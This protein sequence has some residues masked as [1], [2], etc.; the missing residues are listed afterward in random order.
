MFR[1]KLRNCIHCRVIAACDKLQGI[2][3]IGANNRGFK[4]SIDCAFDLDLA[5]TACVSL[6]VSVEQ[7]VLQVRLQKRTIRTR[8]GILAGPEKVVVVQIAPQ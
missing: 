8:Y 3:V 5:E 6:P 1:D 4:T 2:G 7:L